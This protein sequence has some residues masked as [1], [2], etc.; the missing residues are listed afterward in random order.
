[1][2]RSIPMAEQQRGDTA[3]LPTLTLSPDAFSALDT[4]LGHEWLVTNGIGGYAMGTL[5]G[6]TTR[7]YHGYLIAAPRVPQERV[8]LVTTLDERATLAD[9]SQIALGTDEYADGTISPR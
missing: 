3:T 2:S 7:C 1:M 9:G 6:A 4:A 8:A 5:A